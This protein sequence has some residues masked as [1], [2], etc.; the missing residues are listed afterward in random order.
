MAVVTR[1]SQQWTI[2]KSSWREPGRAGC[3][4]VR[5]LDSTSRGS[6][7]LFWHAKL[8]FTF[9]T[10]VF[11]FS[12]CLDTVQ[13]MIQTGLIQNAHNDLV[14]DAAYD[15][16]GLRLATCSLD[17]RSAISCRVGTFSDR[18]F[19]AES[20]YGN[21]MRIRVHGAWRTIGRCA[22]VRFSLLT[23]VDNEVQSFTGP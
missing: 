10:A 7:H 2:G 15:F 9:R 6:D 14:T 17:Q 22:R 16:Y 11:S 21:W 20:K 12:I 8:A 1:S 23:G 13:R 19:C 3:G 5:A 4:Q 18:D